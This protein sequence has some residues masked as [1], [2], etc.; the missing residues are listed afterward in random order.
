MPVSAK[1]IVDFATSDAPLETYRPAPEKCLAGDPVQTVQNIFSNASG[2]MSA[3]L[4]TGAVG[5]HRV[6]YTEDE[7]CQLLTGSVRI[8]SD[9]GQMRDFR[10]G[11]RFVIPA[12]FSGTW[13][14][15]EP[16]SKV[17]VIYEPA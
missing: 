16:A 13:E 10:A 6:H 11:D 1:D 2:V 3:G 14:T 5:T 17:Y 15:R 4:W 7:F 9:D 8:A 12:G